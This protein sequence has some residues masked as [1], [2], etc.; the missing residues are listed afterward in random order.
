VQN[1]SNA[2]PSPV[3]ILI[4][5]QVFLGLNALVGGG[6]F[7]L[8]PDGHLIQMP[9]SNLKN[10]P[11]SDFLIPGL[12]LFIFVGIFPIA[13]AYSLWRRPAWQWPNLL[14]P[15]KRIHWS[16]AGSLAA[17]VI[18]MIWI[19]IQVKWLTVGLLH[20]IIFAWGV[21]LVLVTLLP[22]IRQYYSLIH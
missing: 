17:G 15:F 20:I 11:F 10:T 7:L 13:V 21:L 16:W 4:C 2:R 9:L 12:L 1:H 18:A 8:A 5:L 3:W 6:A 19:T 14:N 22:K